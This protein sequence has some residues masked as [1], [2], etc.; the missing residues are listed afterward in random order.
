MNISHVGYQTRGFDVPNQYYL[1]SILWDHTG[2]QKL[3]FLGSKVHILGQKWPCKGPYVKFY[4]HKSCGVSNSGKKWPKVV[5]L[6]D[7]VHM[8]RINQ[9]RKNDPLGSLYSELWQLGTI[10]RKNWNVLKIS[11]IVQ[12]CRAIFASPSNIKNKFRNIF[13]KKIENVSKFFFRLLWLAKIMRQFCTIAE[14]FITFELF[15][16]IVPS[17][18]S[19]E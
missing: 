14:I 15:L 4:A 17:C 13:K 12:N 10:W 7:W 16:H 18:Q 11:A 19:S 1:F 8:G 6:L 3:P 5:V 9:E 2:G